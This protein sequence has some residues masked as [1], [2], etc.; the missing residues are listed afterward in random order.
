MRKFT[1]GESAHVVIGPRR[2]PAWNLGDA[3]R[4]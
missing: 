3:G 1:E 4:D 2:V